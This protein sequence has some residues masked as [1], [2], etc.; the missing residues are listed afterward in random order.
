MEIGTTTG[1]TPVT[2]EVTEFAVEPTMKTLST[3][4]N[5]EEKFL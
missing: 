2:D 3:D 1:A 5:V 4:S